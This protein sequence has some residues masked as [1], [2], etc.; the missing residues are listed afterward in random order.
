MSAVDDSDKIELHLFSPGS[1][2]SLV[3]LL[4]IVAHYHKNVSALGLWHTVNFGRPWL[5]ESQCEYGL[6]SL[7]YLDGPK[8]EHFELP[9]QTTVN[10]YWLIPITKA[11][12]DYKQQFG[13]EAL[14][15]LFEEKQFN[16][17][18]ANR[19]SVV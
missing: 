12:R 5:G 1:D 14:E 6:I 18:D 16:Y 19:P 3:E 15:T 17:L 8:L 4:T 10:C 13:V 7:P 11:E 2:E 9:E